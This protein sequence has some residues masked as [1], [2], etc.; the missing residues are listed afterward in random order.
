[1]Y[2]FWRVIFSLLHPSQFSPSVL[3]VYT[4]N[5]QRFYILSPAEY[6]VLRAFAPVEAG[7][8]VSHRCNHLY[9][10]QVPPGNLHVHQAQLCA[11]WPALLSHRCTYISHVCTHCTHCD[12]HRPQIKAHLVTSNCAN[13]FMQLN[14]ATYCKILSHSAL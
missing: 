7:V 14:S 6:I 8:E 10:T 11:L 4:F 12:M 2:Y 5:K 13:I 1:M 3:P 9:T